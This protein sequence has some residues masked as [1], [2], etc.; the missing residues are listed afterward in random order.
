MPP[1]TTG[2]G[3]VEPACAW[4][5][6]PAG[7]L[8]G[9]HRPVSFHADAGSGGRT[10]VAG[11]P[12]DGAGVGWGK[13]DLTSTGVGVIFSPS[14]TRMRKM[15]T[16]RMRLI[17]GRLAQL[18]LSQH[19]LASALGVSQPT[20]NAILTGRRAAPAGFKARA[21]Q[22]LDRLE[23]IEQA[24]AEARAKA[25]EEMGAAECNRAGDEPIDVEALPEVL[26]VDDVAALLRCS[27]STLERRVKT[28]AF[29][30]AP[31]RGIDKRWR[32]SKT[33]VLQWLALGGP[34]GAPARGRRSR[35]A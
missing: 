32:W 35:T 7:R 1:T 4:I 27:R 33:A 2:V 26:F 31:I 3:A 19:D 24:V 17:R 20:V 22:A 16:Y 11:G 21:V 15:V 18:R 34:S 12:S 30:L 29:A 25:V 10:D 28:R 14:V 23:R 8:A 5:Q 13:R 9:V 6:G